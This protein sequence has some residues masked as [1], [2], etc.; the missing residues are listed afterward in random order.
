MSE[1]GPPP[2]VSGRGFPGAG[3]VLPGEGREER[4]H[5]KEGGA[6]APPSCSFRGPAR[7]C[8]QTVC[9]PCCA[10]YTLPK[11]SASM[12]K[13]YVVVVRSDCTM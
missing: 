7:K 1:S 2:P 4:A 8:R 9:V 5:N 6:V 13:R 12:E 10:S 11:L 3:P